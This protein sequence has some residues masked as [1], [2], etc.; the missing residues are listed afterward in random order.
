MRADVSSRYH[1]ERG[2]GE[3]FLNHLESANEIIEQYLETLKVNIMSKEIGDVLELTTP[4]LDHSND[5]IQVYVSKSN[6]G[7][8]VSDGGDTI[9][10]LRAFGR[11]FGIDIEKLQ[12][13]TKNVL[14]GFGVTIKDDEL[15]IL[16][17]RVVVGSSIQLLIQAIITIGGIIKVWEI[18]ER[19]K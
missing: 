18:W 6:R 10:E 5:S 9:R 13:I 8:K 12:K 19:V 2:Y 11:A 16:S 14:S 4:F 17:D 1:G 7:C 15:F 3:N